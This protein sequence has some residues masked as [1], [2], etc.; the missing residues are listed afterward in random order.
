MRIRTLIVDDEPH[1]RDGLRLLLAGEPDVDIVEDVG[2]GASALAAIERHAPDLVLLDIELPDMTGLE[3]ADRAPADS[4]PYIIFVTAY[5]RYAVEAF[6]ARA[7]DY[8][9]KPVEPERLRDAV[10]R[11]RERLAAAPAATVHAADEGSNDAGP[12]RRIVA[13]VDGRLV[14]VDIEDVDWIDAQR[15]YVVLHTGETSHRIRQ[16][17][18]WF[19]QRLDPASFARVHRSTIVNLSRV[20]ELVPLHRGEYELILHNGQR[21]FTTRRY[22]DRI[23]SYMGFAGA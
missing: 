11:A 6:R 17:L 23:A 20:R 5:D 7:L 19:E 8:V 4:A 13:A 10:G 2:S 16:K 1:A 15:N 9:L 12:L 14:V 21:L 3:V 22:R 18:S